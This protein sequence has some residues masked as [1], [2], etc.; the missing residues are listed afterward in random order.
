MSY[1]MNESDENDE[2]VLT[3]YENLTSYRYSIP[4]DYIKQ[5]GIYYYMD[6]LKK[7][8]D[9]GR[10]EEL[11]KYVGDK[12]GDMPL[13]LFAI[14]TKDMSFILKI[15]RLHSFSG[16]YPNEILKEDE[17]FEDKIDELLDGYKRY[18]YGNTVRGNIKYTKDTLK[19][20][21]LKR[22]ESTEKNINRRAEEEFMPGGE[23]YETI[24]D[25]YS[26]FF[27][28][29][30]RQKLKGRRMSKKKKKRHNKKTV[31]KKKKMSK[32]KKKLSKNKKKKHNKKRKT[33]K[34]K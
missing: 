31:S 4:I 2:S 27:N 34:K 19:K 28:P 32:K 30:K 14:K 25:R 7:L 5:Q 15:L 9:T 1:K 11:L 18:K 13:L 3:I 23:Y 12:K 21:I 20:D 26:G 24:R 10:L 22:I 29:S 6:K 17:N 33:Y 16:L 8:H